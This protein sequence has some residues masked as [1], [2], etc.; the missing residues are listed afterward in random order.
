MPPQPTACV[1]RALGQSIFRTLQRCILQC[2]DEAHSTGSLDIYST[3]RGL[4]TR[5]LTHGGAADVQAVRVGAVA[6]G[7]VGGASYYYYLSVRTALPL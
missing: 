6:A 2:R 7:M 4:S 1:A 5:E 3:A